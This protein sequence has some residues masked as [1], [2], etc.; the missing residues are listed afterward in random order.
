MADQVLAPKERAPVDRRVVLR[1]TV[2]FDSEGCLRPDSSVCNW[3]R[4]AEDA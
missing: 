1:M 4:G 2:I 3:L